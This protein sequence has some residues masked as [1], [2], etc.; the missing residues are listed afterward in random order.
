MNI[1]QI[2]YFLAIVRTKSFSGAAYD[3]FISQSSISKQIKALEDELNIS[4]FNRSSTQRTLTPAGNI[5]Y[6]Y[7]KATYE[8]H[9]EMLL[10]LDQL[11]KQMSSTLRLGN[12]PV[13][14]MY[15]TFNIGADLALFQKNCQESP[16]NFDI[17]EDT[18][19]AIIK[20]LYNHNADFGLVRLEKIPEPNDFDQLLISHD[21]MVVVVNKTHPLAKVKELSLKKLSNYPIF[22]LSKET[23]LRT[24]I[25]EAFA[26]QGLSIN[27]QGESPRP[28]IIQGMI[29]ESNVTG[30]LPYNVVDL[31]S[32]SDLVI[33]PL[34]EE[35]TSKLVAVRLKEA[36]HHEL[37]QEFWNFICE[38]HTVKNLQNTSTLEPSPMSKKKKM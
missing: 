6:K 22:L 3:L 32:F 34:K 29:T 19:N 37:A 28:K 8:Q 4:L 35:I 7:A 36:K 31:H 24:P 21:R 12:L 13:T 25:I 33:I 2:E 10:E 11:K 20:E 30:L 38:L 27:I 15:K 1:N 26:A 5:F 16:I 18:Q 14:P 23:E 17:F 9:Q